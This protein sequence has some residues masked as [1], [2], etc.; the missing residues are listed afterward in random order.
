MSD[1]QRS[2]NPL[3]KWSQQATTSAFGLMESLKGQGSS[4]AKNLKMFGKTL[5]KESGSSSSLKTPEHRDDDIRLTWLTNRL[6]LA[7]T[8]HNSKEGLLKAEKAVVR[9]MVDCQPYVVVNVHSEPLRL[10]GYAKSIHIPLG[11]SQKGGLPHQ[12]FIRALIPLLNEFCLLTNDAAI[13][14][15]GLDENVVVTAA[16]CLIASRSVGNFNEFMSDSLQTRYERLPTTYRNFLEQTLDFVKLCSFFEKPS[17]GVVLDHIVLEPGNACI[18]GDVYV[19]ISQGVMQ[20]KVFEF[21]TNRCRNEYGQFVFPISGFEIADDAVVFVGE[22]GNAIPLLTCRFNTQLLD[23]NDTDIVITAAE[24]DVSRMIAQPV[25]DLRMI[26]NFS[27]RRVPT[28]NNMQFY[29]YKLLCVRNESE[30]G[31]YQ[32]TYGTLDSDEESPIHRNRRSTP[33]NE[34]KST[35]N[36]EGGSFFETLQFNDSQPAREERLLDDDHVLLSGMTLN[37]EKTFGNVEMGFANETPILSAPTPLHSEGVP[38]RAS[39]TPAIDD[40]LGLGSSVSNESQN[41]TANSSTSINQS[42]SSSNLGDFDFGLPL[43]PTSSSPNTRPSPQQ[44]EFNDLLGGFSPLRPTLNNVTPPN[45][46]NSSATNSKPVSAVNSQSDFEAFLANYPEKQHPQEPQPPSAAS[47]P[48]AHQTRTQ[49]ISS[50]KQQYKPAFGDASTTTGKVSVDAFSD[51]LN[52]GG[53]K[54]TQRENQKQSIGALLNAQQAKNLT[55]EEIKIRDWTQGKERNI[56]ALLCSLQNVLWEGAGR[57]NQPSMADLLTPDQIKKQYRKACLVV[58]PDKLTGSPHLTLARMIFTELNDAYNKHKM[59][60]LFK[61]DD[62]KVRDMLLRADGRAKLSDMYKK[63]GVRTI[64]VRAA[65]GDWVQYLKVACE[66]C[67][68]LLSM[69]PGGHIKKHFERCKKRKIDEE[70]NEEGEESE[71]PRAKSH[72]ITE[73]TE[74]KYKVQELNKIKEAISRYCLRSGRSFNS[75]AS[76]PMKQFIIDITNA[77]IGG[78]GETAMEQLPCRLTIQKNTEN[79]AKDLIEETFKNLE[80]F[81]GKRLNLVIDHGKLVCNYLSVYGSYVDDNFLLCVVP[82]AFIPSIDGKSGKETAKLIVERFH[83]YGWTKEE[84]LA[85][86]VTADGA[87]KTLGD[88]FQSYIRCVNHSLNLLA[89]KAITPF[90][91]HAK[92]LFHLRPH[93]E[94]VHEVLRHAKV[95]ASGVRSNCTMCQLMTRHPSLPIETRWMSNLKCLKDIMDLRNEIEQRSSMLPLAARQA[96]SSISVDLFPVATSILA[97]LG[98]LLEYNTLFQTQ[99]AISLHL[100]LPTY[101][102]VKLQWEKFKSNSNENFD[103]ETMDLEVSQA[104]AEAGLLALPIYYSEF[105]DIHYAAVLLYSQEYVDLTEV[106]SVE[107]YWKRKR[108]EFPNLFEAACYVFGV[109]PSE[110]VLIVLGTQIA[111]KFPNKIY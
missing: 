11:I 21:A 103:P 78:F 27:T 12:P 26:L 57:W 86:R 95:I 68:T 19:A 35:N 49:G 109:I 105:N 62:K 52:Q 24:M 71:Q 38:S 85:C 23:S 100:V 25:Q 77:L 111:Q 102:H 75:L 18:D 64:F 56:R 45:S 73:F 48:A 43:N 15:F 5:M 104:I 39:P 84:V 34:K 87:L 101:K 42:N 22:K 32:Q 51:L 89:A 9:E 58:H 53:F 1:G 8:M 60:D 81:R 110:A 70:N 6:V 44:P 63:D 16:F 91:K 36:G 33:K 20:L 97:V 99:T 55:P 3:E 76:Q 90:E 10:D 82:M 40:L 107:C 46:L 29:R 2:S 106:E 59:A 96:L 7:D 80:L 108:Q 94:K 65:D 28:L 54:P 88:Y 4:L 37:D 92:D 93:L 17:I 30:L 69:G 14:I 41:L 47:N 79:L 50:Q 74:K 72:K 13:V 66:F 61:L 31:G 98:P 67:L 83:E